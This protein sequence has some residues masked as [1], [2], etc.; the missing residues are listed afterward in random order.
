MN[1]PDSVV[2]HLV[3]GGGP[4]GSAVALRLAQ[5]GK[6]VTL[7]EKEREPRHKVCGE[8]LSEE[9]IAYLARAGI[10]P[11]ALGAHPI[12]FLRLFAGRRTAETGLPFAALSLS[13]RVL[14]A[15]ILDRATEQG[16]SVLRGACV[17]RLIPDGD[18]WN[19]TIAGGACI[20]ARTVFLASGKHDL[21]G[22]ARSRGAHSDLVGFKMH[23]RLAPAQTLALR[24]WM[25]LFL[26][27]GGYGG[28]SLVEDGVANLCFVVKRSAWR[29]LAE[30]NHCLRSILEA[31]P[32]LRW[33]M[34]NAQPLWAR[35]LAI[36]PIPYGYL[37]KDASP[38]WCVGDQAAVIPSFTGDGMS[39]SLHSANL[40]AQIFLS[41]GTVDAYHR[42]LEA[43][44]G[45]SM[46][47]S[48]WISRAMVTSFGR[49]LAIAGT[50]FLPAWMRWIAAST[51]IP[52]QAVTLADSAWASSK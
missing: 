14:D 40:A 20:R 33:R 31:V 13:R 30:W 49:H 27:P 39:I 45:R 16:C 38:L 25:E 11:Q 34:A 28:L 29:K 17:E 41:G 51:R 37:R 24:E 1:M 35:P 9:A 36:S 7:L 46:T 5:A 8:F 22:W 48:T 19:A 18:Q 10:F 44:V 3:I 6:Q 52:A 26:F 32:G 50:R 4:A 43:Q 23:W 42:A 47:L 2:D 21:H 15:A 12:R